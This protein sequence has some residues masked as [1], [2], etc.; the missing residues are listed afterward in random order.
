L[1]HLTDLAATLLAS[2]E[3]DGV[4]ETV[5]TFCPYAESRH[6][7]SA[8]CFRDVVP[9]EGRVN[10][11]GSALFL[12]VAAATCPAA[13]PETRAK[14][15]A[16]VSRLI[17]LG[18]DPD[19][20]G[21]RPG[22]GYRCGLC[23]APIALCLA[24]AEEEALGRDAPGFD[25][26]GADPTASVAAVLLAAGKG[27]FDSFEDASTVSFPVS[28]LRSVDVNAVTSFAHVPTEREFRWR[29]ASG[30]GPTEREPEREPEQQSGPPL[31]H[32]A[33]AI[34]EGA[35][36]FAV[37]VA[38]MLLKLG[39]DPDATGSRPGFCGPGTSALTLCVAG[40]KNGSAFPGEARVRGFDFDSEPPG[41]RKRPIASGREERSPR[42]EVAS[43]GF[44]SSSRSSGTAVGTRVS[45]RPAPPT[46]EEAVRMRF[47]GIAASLEGARVAAER[48][49]R[50]AVKDLESYLPAAEAGVD[51]SSRESR[52]LADIFAT[53][54]A[55]VESRANCNVP[56]RLLR[57]H[58]DHLE[59]DLAYPLG[60]CVGL[61]AEGGGDIPRRVASALVE[62]GNADVSQRG[63]CAFPLVA[64]PLYAATIAIRENVP[65]SVDVFRLLLRNGADVDGAG[66]YPEGSARTP[67]I[68]LLRVLKDG[69]A[70]RPIVVSLIENLLES[71][72]DVAASYP[73]VYT[74]E[75]H[76]AYAFQAFD[77]PGLGF[78]GA[79]RSESPDGCFFG[80][81]SDG[82][83]GVPGRFEGFSLVP[84]PRV[85]R[86]Q[87]TPLFWAFQAVRG[88]GFDEARQAVASL[89]EKLRGD[90]D[91]TQALN[92]Y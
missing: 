37:A 47:R 71:S 88:D 76:P 9:Y 45:A 10:T 57:P 24:A 90:V 36:S 23:L 38:R 44:E 48:N 70:S 58:A 87:Y 42:K 56:L 35:G 22:T 83:S 63:V 51:R 21:D 78:K 16:I 32:A 43:G 8:R 91:Q 2:G 28:S 34:V 77:P 79:R 30:N 25:S 82:S 86:C 68:E 12:A 53:T 7:S 73:E 27:P 5:A 41:S 59:T 39:A 69:G 33:C 31:W 18:A 49:T 4:F 13:S 75:P 52:V 20:R 6:A 62:R 29:R 81:D 19:K 11:S 84:R 74:S 72:C 15:A 26:I 14:C 67:L 40:L 89:V 66:V 50:R 17:V 80:T 55:L 46:T 54:N 3:G 64:S 92:Q 61:F 85:G 60:T 65:G 1:A